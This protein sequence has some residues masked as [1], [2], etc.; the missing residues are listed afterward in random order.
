MLF[1]T[2]ARYAVMAILDI[3]SQDLNKPVALKDISVRQNIT[4]KYLEQIMNRLSKALI[5]KSIKGPGGG[6]VLL[7]K[8][9]TIDKIIDAVD[10]SIKITRCN[11]GKNC[12]PNN[13]LCNSHYLW[14]GLTFEIREYFSNI[15]IEDVVSGRFKENIIHRMNLNRVNEK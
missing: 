11:A 3:G 15:S 6:Y 1:T 8:K 12:M 4:V 5:I 14:D 2:K 7:S 10:E 9:I 13:A